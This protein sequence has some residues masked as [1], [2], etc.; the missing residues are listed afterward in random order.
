MSAKRR[1][2]ISKKQQRKYSKYIIVIFAVVLVCLL[3]LFKKKEEK[4]I[5]FDVEIPKPYTI[6][7][8]DVSRY[9]EK[10]DWEKIAGARSGKDSLKISFAFIKATDRKSV[11]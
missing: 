3:F 8:I 6:C 1:W 9:Q 11:V 5:A 2:G 4:R 10:I 7:G